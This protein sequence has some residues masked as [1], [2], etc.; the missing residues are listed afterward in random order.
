MGVVKGIPKGHFAWITVVVP[1]MK[2][3]D[4]KKA[5]ELYFQKIVFDKEYDSLIQ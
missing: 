1:L 5:F 2:P 4:Y 3:L